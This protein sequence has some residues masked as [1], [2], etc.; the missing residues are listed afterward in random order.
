[1][2]T[3]D[4]EQTRNS[5]HSD[6]ASGTCTLEKL[7]RNYSASRSCTWC[8]QA[9]CL[10]AFFWPQRRKL[11]LMW[12]SLFLLFLCS[13]QKRRRHIIGQKLRTD[14][15]QILNLG[16][17]RVR[18][19]IEKGLAHLNVNK[20]LSSSRVWHSKNW[21]SSEKKNL[22]QDKKVKS[23][24]IISPHNSRDLADKQD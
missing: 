5:D 23:C 14:I 9:S 1:M 19:H 2:Q 6:W 18:W 10:V 11:L 4:F 21:F 13:M 8:G 7:A 15:K 20:D 22:Q 16:R 17:V 12:S 3:H 24:S